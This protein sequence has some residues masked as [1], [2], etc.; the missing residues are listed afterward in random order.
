MNNNDN[1]RELK[2]IADNFELRNYSVVVQQSLVL[3]EG[4]LRELIK[5]DLTQLESS[6]QV[7]VVKYLA[8]KDKAIDDLT[9]GEIVGLLRE[10]K[11]FDVWKRTFHEDLRVFET[12][13]LH[14]L[15][16]LRNEVTHGTRLTQTRQEAKLVLFYLEV[17]LQSFN[18]KNKHDHYLINIFKILWNAII[19]VFFSMGKHDEISVN[20]ARKSFE[21]P[22]KENNVIKII[23]ITLFLI[24]LMVYIKSSPP[25]PVATDGVL[26]SRFYCGNI[27]VIPSVECETLINLYYSTNGDKWNRNAEWLKTTDVCNWV[28][29]RCEGGR[30]IYLMLI[31]NNLRGI[32]PNL[33]QLSALLYFDISNNMLCRD[34]NTRYP[35]NWETKLTEYPLCLPR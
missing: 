2:A 21:T 33:S 28:G 26:K 11:F 25:T 3:I 1:S 10:T 19:Q 20:I 34:T 13:D 17:V 7:A 16:L 9:M 6:V 12:I 31:G 8:N 32:I 27:T 5:R 30:V 4:N 24:L 29:V 18:V 14:K 22:N 15:V 23:F 35:T